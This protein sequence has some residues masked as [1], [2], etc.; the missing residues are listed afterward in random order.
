ME[1]L[2]SSC[3]YIATLELE[4]NHLEQTLREFLDRWAYECQQGDGIHED[5]FELYKRALA[6][7]NKPTTRRQC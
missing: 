4:I 5:A 7:V 3:I 2:T 1:K 6:L